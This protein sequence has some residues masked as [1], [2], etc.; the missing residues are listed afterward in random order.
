MTT[1]AVDVRA[2]NSV[3]GGGGSAPGVLDGVGTVPVVVGEGVAKVE[4]DGF[5]DGNVL[6]KTWIAGG[7]GVA[8]DPALQTAAEDM[9]QP[10]TPPLFEL[11]DVLSTDFGAEFDLSQDFWQYT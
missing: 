7:G 5:V 6:E 2:E 4:D 8:L 1:D 3:V 11:D 9:A 10:A